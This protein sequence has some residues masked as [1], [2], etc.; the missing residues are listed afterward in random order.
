VNSSENGVILVHFLILLSPSDRRGIS[1]T[2]V[3]QI[4]ELSLE[5]LETLG[6]ALLDFTSL[7][8][9]TTWLSEIEI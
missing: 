3:Q 8:D 1:S 4:R 9:L 7:T 5:Q 6:E 2:L